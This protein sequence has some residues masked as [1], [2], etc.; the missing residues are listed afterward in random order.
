MFPVWLSRN[1]CLQRE[2]PATPSDPRPPTD[3]QMLVSSAG[4]RTASWTQSGFT[5][6]ENALPLGR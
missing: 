2:G 5:R 1:I 6:A 3:A 4:S